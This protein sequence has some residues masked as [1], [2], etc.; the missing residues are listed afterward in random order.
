MIRGHVV[1]DKKKSLKAPCYTKLLKSRNH[2][3]ESRLASQLTRKKIHHGAARQN[4]PFTRISRNLRA[5]RESEKTR[6]QN[7]RESPR[8]PLAKLAI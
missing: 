1:L 4:T 6:K 5:A 3:R 7:Q 8:S 2:R